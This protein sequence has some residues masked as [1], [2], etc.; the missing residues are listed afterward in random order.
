M[1][2]IHET[3]V[4]ISKEI[5]GLVATKKAGSGIAFAYRGIDD[6]VTHL[7]DKLDEA[8]VLYWPSRIVDKQVNVREI[9]GGKAITT[10]SLVVEYTFLSVEDGSE[11]LVHVP[12]FAQDFAD[13]NDAQAMSVALRTALIQ[14]FRLQ[15]GDKDP[16]VTGE[17][18]NR[19]VEKAVASTTTKSATAKKKSAADV[20]D[21]IANIIG[22]PE[23]PYDGET[24]NALGKKHS[25]G[26][27]PS[28]W[29]GDL[30]VLEA[31]LN[32]VSKGEVA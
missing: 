23:E 30:K 3:I 10:T 32:S 6:V 21:E 20:R 31:V 12:G 13:R 22:N 25:G 1:A 18:A 5:G 28:Q 26:K 11:L 14:I 4:D 9:A 27:E 15:G 17:E 19:E 24:I 7:K 16:E 29:M 2:R 8:G